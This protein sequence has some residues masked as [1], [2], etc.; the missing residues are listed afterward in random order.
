[1]SEM[2]YLDGQPLPQ[3]FGVAEMADLVEISGYDYLNG[4]LEGKF[5]APT[6]SKAL[7][8]RLSEVSEGEVTFTGIPSSEYM[9]PIGTVHGGYAATL[10]DSA[11]ACAVHSICPIGHASTTVELK[12]NYVRPIL[13]DTGRLFA[14]GKVIHPGRQLAT[15]EAKLTDENGKLF[16]H[17]T[18]TCSV[19]KIPV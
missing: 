14:R 10:L 5:P 16:A 8:F 12:L 17:G 3:G 9:N 1:M 6:I 7:N 15:S 13:P 2:D 19:F 18:Q 4:I 11:L